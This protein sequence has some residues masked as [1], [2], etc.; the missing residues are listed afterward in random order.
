M[1]VERIAVIVKYRVG[2]GNV[3]M[4]KVVH[5]QLL[6]AEE[7]GHAIEGN[8]MRYPD[9]E[10]WLSEN[11]RESDCHSHEVEVYQLTPNK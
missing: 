2:L 4:P 3:K 5:E 6:K 10:I 1:E 8:D 7:K 9:A 11:I